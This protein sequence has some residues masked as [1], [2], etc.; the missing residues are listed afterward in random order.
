MLMLPLV[1]MPVFISPLEG[2]VAEPVLVDGIPDPGAGPA[3]A[4]GLSIAPREPNGQA[5]DKVIVIP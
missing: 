1:L 4:P 5:V 3:L 2:A